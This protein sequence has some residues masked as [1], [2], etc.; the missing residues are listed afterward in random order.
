MWQKAGPT[1]VFDDTLL[2]DSDRLAEADTEGLLRALAMAGAQVRA[3]S[4][5]AAELGMA[6]RLDIGRPRALVL[7]SRPGGGCEA[8][9]VL[10]ELLAGSS[11][12]PII[13][14]D[15]VPSWVGTLDVVFA[16]ADDPGDPELAAELDRAARHGAAVVVSSAD[17][18]PVAAAVAGRG[19]LLATHLRLPTESSFPR[20]LA[21]GLLT[22]NA[23]GLTVVD[24]AVLADLLDEEAERCHLSRDPDSNPAKSLALRLAERAPLL[25]GLDRA[26][27]AVARQAEHAFATHAATVCQVSGYRQLQMRRGLYRAALTD[28]AG[29]DIF[30]D[31]DERAGAAAPLRVVLLGVHAGP[32]SDET[33]RYAEQVFPAAERLLPSEEQP[34]GE[35]TRAAVLALRCELAAA[36]LGLATGVVGGVAASAAGRP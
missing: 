35:P 7:V 26:A 12:V 3:T 19:M 8:A 32:V 33:R 31:R 9:T 24:V 10:S 11:S 15:V 20:A 27:V 14:S 5:A 18:G 25:V 28:Q 34:S 4:D 36:Y 21:A 29:H 6:E 16:H 1:M 2:A 30:A 13:V 17:E 22:T 23:L